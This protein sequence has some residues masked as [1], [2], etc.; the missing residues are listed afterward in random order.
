VSLCVATKNSLARRVLAYVIATA[1]SVVRS[2]VDSDAPPA[3]VG[4][5][6]QRIEKT[7]LSE[8]SPRHSRAA[9]GVE[10][11]TV[12]D[13]RDSG[14]GISRSGTWFGLSGCRPGPSYAPR[15]CRSKTFLARTAARF[16]A[17]PSPRGCAADA[18][19]DGGRRRPHRLRRTR[20]GDGPRG[21]G[22]QRDGVSA[23]S[24]VAIARRSSI[25][26]SPSTSERC[27]GRSVG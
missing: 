8:S 13:R 4:L 23:G 9:V 21:G 5:Q 2:S 25:P 11:T 27:G 17:D 14:E 16:G 10:S 19:R 1:C 15:P 18:A 24:A 7:R 26:T 20:C 12:F 22:V 6:P 3:A